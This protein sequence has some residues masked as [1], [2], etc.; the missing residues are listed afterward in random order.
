M[1][2]AAALLDEAR[3]ERQLHGK[4]LPPRSTP[5]PAKTVFNVGQAQYQPAHLHRV[6]GRPRRC[7]AGS[8]APCYSTRRQNELP[9]SSVP[10][11]VA[12]AFDPSLASAN[13]RVLWSLPPGEADAAE[14]LPLLLE[15]LCDPSADCRFLA[16]QGAAELIDASGPTGGL[17]PATADVIPPI[18]AAL[19]TMDP[20]VVCAALQ[21]LRQFL[22]SHKLAGAALRPHYRQLLPRLAPLV[23]RSQERQLRD[24]SLDRLSDR[25]MH[26]GDLVASTLAEMEARGG[27]GAGAEIKTVVPSWRPAEEEL[28][29]GFAAP[30]FR[31][32]DVVVV[33]RGLVSHV[34]HRGTQ[35]L[36]KGTACG[37]T[38]LHGLRG[39]RR[40]R[41]EEAGGSPISSRISFLL[42]YGPRSCKKES[43]Q[44]DSWAGGTAVYSS[45]QCTHVSFSFL[46]TLV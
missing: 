45:D 18:R 16:A 44:H 42:R 36:A 19:G 39:S 37:T 24:G 15:G 17:L 3:R 1:T 4:A 5:A 2:A 28:H 22:G 31:N 14:L 38:T 35:V 12:G 21:L 20:P 32:G 41:G 29:R 30:E 6:S 27:A 34:G 26:P 33:A 43:A 40:V 7:R 9:A 46:Q 25:E 13:K 10:A 8:G 23:L 11:P